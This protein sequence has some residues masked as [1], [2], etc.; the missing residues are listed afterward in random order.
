MGVSEF[1]DGGG[2][3]GEM[4]FE[5]RTD[6]CRS[7]SPFQNGGPLRHW[8]FLVG[9]WL[10]VVAFGRSPTFVAQSLQ[11]LENREADEYRI[12]NRG[13]LNVEVVQLF[14]MMDH[15]DIRFTWTP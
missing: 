7:G 2:V 3:W 8:K 10:F 13:I 4:I 12:S 14:E 5:Y 9:Y 6:E 1:S 15:L 11:T